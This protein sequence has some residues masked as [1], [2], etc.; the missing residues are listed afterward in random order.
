MTERVYNFGAGPGA[1]PLPVLEQAQRELVSLPSI[2]ASPLEVSHRG[3][4][5]AAVIQETEANLRELLAVPAGHH[6]LFCQ[7]GATMQFSMCAMN[8]LRGADSPADY[9]VTG[10]WGG[11]A[12]HEA[13]KEGRV[14]T[15]WS[16][17]EGGF[18]RVPTTE[19]LAEAASPDAAYLHLTTNETIQGVEF[20][21]VPPVEAA[22]PE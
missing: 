8:L 14:R 7:G 12:L 15:A 11:K 3:S 2:G 6:V 10:S 21:D 20:R 22:V 5:F 19:E 1:L 16:G 18:V 4:W 9:V 17:K 13:E